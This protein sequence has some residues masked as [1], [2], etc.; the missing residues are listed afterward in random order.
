MATIQPTVTFPSS[1]SV[2][3]VW[4]TVTENDT[5]A[6]YSGMS[7]YADRTV[8]FT[9]TPGSSTMLFEGSNDDTNFVTLNDPLG[10]A[11]SLSSNGLRQVLEYTE[12]VRP[13]FTG[14]SGQS[15]TTTLVAKRMR[16]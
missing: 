9:G 15:V 6:T 2:K 16:G 11:I 5:A 13:R 4:T 1:D 10:T 14:G 7:E 8:Q 12:S 3:V